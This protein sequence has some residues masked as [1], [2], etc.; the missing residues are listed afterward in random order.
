MT[1][2]IPKPKGD[3]AALVANTIQPQI[4]FTW[5]NRLVN[6]AGCERF[7]NWNTGT[8][9]NGFHSRQDGDQYSYKSLDDDDF[10]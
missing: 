9:N 10:W 4:K 2:C 5:F 1:K 6:Q 3:N 7:M 8:L